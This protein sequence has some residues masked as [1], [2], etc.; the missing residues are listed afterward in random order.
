MYPNLIKIFYEPQT[1]APFARNKGLTEAKGEW[2]QFLDSDDELLPDKLKHQFELIKQNSNIDIVVG[3]FYKLREGVNALNKKIIHAEHRNPWK[4][5][6]KSGLG[7]TSSILWKKDVIIAAGGWN[8]KISSSQE[9]DLL[10]RLLQNNI[11][12]IYLDKPETNHYVINNSISRSDNDER[13]I[14]ILNNYI[15]LR[16]SIK[17]YLISKGIYSKKMRQAFNT[18]I[19]FKLKPYKKRFP[20]YVE[21]K[22]VELNLKLPVHYVIRENAKKFKIRLKN[23][24]FRPYKLNELYQ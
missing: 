2:L 18:S 5:L 20:D 12:I 21:M 4:G 10:F 11:S 15:N 7:K 16:I 23:L 6:L 8:E 9:Y 19:Y 1:E 22:R 24:I 17:D 3:S 14:E 13:M